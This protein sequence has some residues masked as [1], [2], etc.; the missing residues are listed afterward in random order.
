[1][2]FPCVD[3]HFALFAHV[4]CAV[5]AVHVVVTGGRYIIA[6]VDAVK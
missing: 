6:H 5:V 4:S 2:D 3:A 1:M